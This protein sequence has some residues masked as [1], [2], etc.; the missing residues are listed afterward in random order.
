MSNLYKKI[1]EPKT[2]EEIITKSIKGRKIILRYLNKIRS[3]GYIE[4]N[5]YCAP[6]QGDSISC[7]SHKSLIKIGETWNKKNINDKITLSG[8]KKE[9]WTRLDN[10]FKER[11]P[12]NKEYCWLNLEE[13]ENLN[14]EEINSKTFRPKMPREWL[15][16]SKAWLSTTDIGNVLNQYMEIL[17]QQI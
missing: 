4:D 15:R 2:G 17:F 10:K 14:D 11:A 1:I 13:I 5:K 16:N 3:G 6:G 7:F 8:N 12:C 9:L